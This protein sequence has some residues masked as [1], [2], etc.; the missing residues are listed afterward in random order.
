LYEQARDMI[1]YIKNEKTS[2]IITQIRDY[3][4]SKFTTRKDAAKAESL[5]LKEALLTTYQNS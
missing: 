5:P 4:L 2:Y 1:Q 3:M